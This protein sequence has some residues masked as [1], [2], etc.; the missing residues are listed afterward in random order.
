MVSK[1]AQTNF[2]LFSVKLDE[3]KQFEISNCQVFLSTGIPPVHPPT[4]QE[5]IKIELVQPLK[6][7]SGKEQPFLN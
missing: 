6:K 1:T 7:I 5:A 2:S 3:F 4:K